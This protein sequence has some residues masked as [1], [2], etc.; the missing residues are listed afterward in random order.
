MPKQHN[1]VAMFREMVSCR[2]K[3]LRALS[4]GE[5]GL[6]ANSPVEQLQVGSR[7]AAIGIIVERK[8]EG[9][10]LVV[11]QGFMEARLLPFV[12]HVALDGFYKYPDG[13]VTPLSDQDESRF[14]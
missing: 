6:L 1:P 10:L 12:K 4:F 11:L 2:G 5:L 9:E 14:S 3:K 8:R 13:K 7:S